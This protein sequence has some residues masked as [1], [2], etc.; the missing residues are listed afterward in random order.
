VIADFRSDQEKEKKKESDHTRIT[1]ESVCHRET[2]SFAGLV[3]RIPGD[4]GST[5]TD[6]GIDLI[7][8]DP[9]W[10]APKDRRPLS[11][12]DRGCGRVVQ[13][14]DRALSV[15][16][17]WWAGPFVLAHAQN[18]RPALASPQTVSVI[19]RAYIARPHAR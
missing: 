19:E 2:T 5:E 6:R 18:A 9:A 11:P 14:S 13:Y 16:V 10:S 3:A 7:P 12:G 17:A 8:V 4:R 1:T 15:V